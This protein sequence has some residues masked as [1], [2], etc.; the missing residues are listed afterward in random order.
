ME[1][2]N[3]PASSAV[4]RVIPK[5]SFDA[6]AS[7]AQ[8]ALFARQVLRILWMYK[9]AAS[10]INLDGETIHEIQVMRI[11]LK[12]RTYIHTLL[13]LIDRSIPYA[14]IFQVQYGEECYLSAAAKRPHPAHPDVSVID[15]A[16]RTDWFRP[17]PGLY[18]LDLRI[19]LDAVYLDFCRKL[20]STPAP[21][22]IGLEQ[23]ATR[24]RELARLRR[25]IEQLKR[26][27]SYTPEFS[28]RVE[29]N[30]ELKKREEE[31]KRL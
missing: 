25:E 31:F 7:K 3:L 16:F 15:S 9:L 18:P 24:E 10:T 13:D 11:D 27:I 2:F 19:S 22:H 17:A 5:N 6:Q 12:L 30:I 14:I 23:L 26:K 29:L 20:V 8:T 28:R 21:A 4:N 1:L